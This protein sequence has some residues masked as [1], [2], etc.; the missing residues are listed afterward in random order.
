M[1]MCT[2][3]TKTTGLKP[4]IHEVIELNIKPLGGS[5]MSY[6]IKPERPELYEENVQKINGIS[7]TVA[8][9]FPEKSGVMSQILNTFEGGIQAIGHVFDFDHNMIR[10]TFG[11]KFVSELFKGGHIDTA[12]LLEKQNLKYLSGGDGPKFKSVA[13]KKVCADLGIEFTD[14]CTAIEKLYGEILKW[15]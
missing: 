9:S 2:I 15:Q 11:Q 8:G 14:K 5:V 4:G 7:A 6:R 1:L 3:S 12:L 10:N 13:L